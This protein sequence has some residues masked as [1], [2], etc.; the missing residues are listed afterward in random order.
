MSLSTPDLERV[1]DR[2][3][4]AIDQAPEDRSELMLVKL[5]LL[6]AR[7]LGDVERFGTLLQAALQ[8][9]GPSRP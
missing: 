8:D 5:V 3:A 2:L 9:L 7:E 1:Y 4:E 6:M